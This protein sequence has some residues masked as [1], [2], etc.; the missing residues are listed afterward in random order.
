VRAACLIAIQNL[1]GPAHLERFAETLPR[2]VAE[3]VIALLATRE[4][5]D[6]PA[7]TLSRLARELETAL[8]PLA[9]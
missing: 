6:R 7:S 9:P 8:A 5:K 2:R 4:S 3:R 1:G